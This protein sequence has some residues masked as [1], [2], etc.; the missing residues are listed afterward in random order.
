MIPFVDLSR[1]INLNQKDKFDDQDV[2]TTLFCMGYLTLAPGKA[3]ALVCPN[4]TIQEQ[5]F[6][7]YF[8]Y[9]SGLG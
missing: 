2:L 9:L 5:F 7:Y 1:T 3:K 4:K 8:K 6:G